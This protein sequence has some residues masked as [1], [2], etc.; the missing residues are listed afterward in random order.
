MDFNRAE[1]TATELISLGQFQI[2]IGFFSY[3]V[4]RAMRLYVHPRF[5]SILELCRT[6]QIVKESVYI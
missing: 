5:G 1:P 4:L 6:F 2:I 3:I